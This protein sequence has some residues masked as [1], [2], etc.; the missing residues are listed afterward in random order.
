MKVKF[1]SDAQRDISDQVT[2]LSGKT[3]SGVAAFRDIIRRAL[4]LLKGQPT[5]GF[6]DSEIPI[7]GAKRIIVAGWYFDYDITDDTIWVQ[8]IT[9]S[10]NTPSLRYDDD[11][12]YED[13]S[14]DNDGTED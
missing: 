8:R 9:S 6:T 2:Y 7:R 10:V 11:F 13:T 1:S 3:I 5:S 12:D 14:P 4:V